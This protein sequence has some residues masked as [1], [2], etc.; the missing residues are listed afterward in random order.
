MVVSDICGTCINPAGQAVEDM[1]RYD[2]AKWL[3][4]LGNENS[5]ASTVQKALLSLPWYLPCFKNMWV[6]C[7]CLCFLFVFIFEKESS[8]VIQAG[9]KLT[10]LHPRMAAWQGCQPFQLQSHHL[11]TSGPTGKKARRFLLSASAAGSPGCWTSAFF[12]PSWFRKYVM[13]WILNFPYR[14][15]VWML[16]AQLV[17]LV[18]EVMKSLGWEGSSW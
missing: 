4:A 17:T 18:W 5:P 16:G 8:C 3:H 6:F 7:C 13:L 2:Q 11:C 1:E 12:Q 9:L 14:P 10:I 15:H